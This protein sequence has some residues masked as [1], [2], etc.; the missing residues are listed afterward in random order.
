GTDMKD[1]IHVAYVV[2][3]YKLKRQFVLK[4]KLD[5]EK[6]VVDTVES[7]WLAANWHERETYD[8]LGVQFAGHPDLR[9]LLLPDDWVGYPL[10]KDYAEQPEYHGMP[11]KREPALGNY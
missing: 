9:R 2:T 3:S 8:L 11:T 4:V 6:P 5:R 10:R 7:V 1:S